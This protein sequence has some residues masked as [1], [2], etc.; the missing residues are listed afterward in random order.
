VSVGPAGR[1][2][3]RGFSAT[4][5]DGA[6]PSARYI[7]EAAQAAEALLEAIGRSDGTRASVTRELR[8]LEIEDG[9]LGSFRFD[10]NGDMTPPTISVFRVTGKRR[11]A[12][13]PDFYGG[14]DFDRLVRV[15][16]ELVGS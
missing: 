6:I 4:Q 2:F 10:E 14:A 1:R 11:E 13:A 5:P 12:D 16:P 7:L 8:R 9:I 3:L 15:A